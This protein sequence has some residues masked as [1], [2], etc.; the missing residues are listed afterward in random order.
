M[1]KTEITNETNSSLFQ[2]NGIPVWQPHFVPIFLDSV[3]VHISRKFML[4]QELFAL[5]GGFMKSI[6]M[7]FL[8]V[9]SFNTRYEKGIFLAKRMFEVK[10]KEEQESS[11]IEP[12]V[13]VDTIVAKKLK[14]EQETNVWMSGLRYYLKFWGRSKPEFK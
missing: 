13:K 10:V 2:I 3:E 1:K 14:I 4:I 11:Y 7:V 8:F 6:V 12:Q 9:S 5:V